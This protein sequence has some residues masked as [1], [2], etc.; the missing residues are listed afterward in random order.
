MGE[1]LQLETCEAYFALP[2][3][4]KGPGVIVLQEWWGLV[5]HIESICDRLAAEGFVALAPD[6]YGGQSTKEP[7]EAGEL[8]MS[9][10]V[11][12]TATKLDSVVAFLAGHEAVTSA[13]VGIMGFCMGGKL[14]M[15]EACRAAQIGACINF[16]GVHPNFEPDYATLQAPLQG[17]FAEHDDYS[18]PKVVDELD[19]LLS[20]L[21]KSFEFH[22][23]A[24]A[25][26]AFFNDT[27]PEVYHPE[28]AK[29]AHDRMVS[30]LRTHLV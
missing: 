10:R 23:Y 27:R 2:E 6:L 20:K 24:G 12:E 17:H 26:H 15:Y 4:G 7:D 21:G 29:L 1:R 13:K 22:R 16:Y 8:M 18:S 30:F 11:E 5:P 28:F 14:A 19:A 3:S 9:L 25:H